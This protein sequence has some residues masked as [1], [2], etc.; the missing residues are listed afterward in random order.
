[1]E[2]QI[3]DFSIIGT[4]NIRSWWKSKGFHS[5]FEDYKFWA[6]LNT[7]SIWT[8]NKLRNAFLMCFFQVTMKAKYH[9]LPSD[10]SITYS[11]EGFGQMIILNSE[12]EV[13]YPNDPSP[14]SLCWYLEH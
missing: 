7:I 13:T 14:S 2:N 1:M 10:Y 12:T 11:N 3:P 4:V 8:L 9:G 5:G 6:V